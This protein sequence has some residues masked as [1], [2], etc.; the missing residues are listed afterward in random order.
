ME[1]PR[2]ALVVKISISAAKSRSIMTMKRQ[3][4]SDDNITVTQMT[5]EFDNSV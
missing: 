1:D 3:D 5:M 2:H 4:V